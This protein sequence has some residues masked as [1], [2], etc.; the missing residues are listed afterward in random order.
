MTV[1]KLEF[2]GSTRKLALDLEASIVR[3]AEKQERMGISTQWELG[4]EQGIWNL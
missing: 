4:C 2:Y 3:E 1:S